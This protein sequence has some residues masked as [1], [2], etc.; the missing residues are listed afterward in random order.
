MTQKQEI[1]RCNICGNIV[2]VLHNSTGIL[3]CCKNPMELLNEKEEGTG[4]EKHLPVIEETDEGVKV[5]IGLIPHPMEENH[6]IEMVEII[7][8]GN[9]FRKLLKPGDKPEAEFEIKKEDI[10][11]IQIREYCSIHGLWKS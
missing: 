1:Y 10:N 4:T 3:E 2:E 5:K 9:I 11:K 8:D 6:C 7:T